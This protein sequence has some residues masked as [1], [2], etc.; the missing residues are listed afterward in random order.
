MSELG[1]KFWQLSPDNIL[2]AMAEDA[3]KSGG[4]SDYKVDIGV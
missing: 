2:D 3:K 1:V 4:D